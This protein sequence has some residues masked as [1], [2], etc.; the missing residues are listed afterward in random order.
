MRTSPFLRFLFLMIFCAYTISP[1]AQTAVRVHSGITASMPYDG[2][3]S[4]PANCFIAGDNCRYQEALISSAVAGPAG[5]TPPPD[6]QSI[7]SF[8]CDQVGTNIVWIWVQDWLGQWT[9]SPSVVIQTDEE[10]VCPS[11]SFQQTAEFQTILGYSAALGSGGELTMHARDF[12]T[13]FT[14]HEDLS[15]T[16]SFSPDPA[17]SLRTFT[18]EDEEVGV[19]QIYMHASDSFPPPESNSFLILYDNSGVCDNTEEA[20]GFH[21]LHLL[22]LQLPPSGEMTLKA[23]D[24]IPRSAPKSLTYAFSNDPADTLLRLGCVDFQQFDGNAQAIDIFAIAEDGTVS[25]LESNLFLYDDFGHCPTAYQPANDN[26]CNAIPL[27]VTN[28]DCPYRLSNVGAS[29]EAGEVA[30]PAGAC[31][32][33]F[34]WCDGASVDNSLWFTFE[35][36]ASGSVGVEATLL[37]TQIAIWEA[38]DCSSLTNGSAILV[39][40]DDDAGGGSAEARLEAVNFLIPGQ[41]YYLQV[42]G[43]TGDSGSFDLYIW[44]AGLLQELTEGSPACTAAATAPVSEGHNRWLHLLGDDG[45]LIASVADGGNTLGALDGS[46]QVNDG[47]IRR[48][49]QG[50]PYLDRNW[51]ISTAEEAAGPVRLRLYFTLEEFQALQGAGA[52]I[53]TPTQLFL[54]RVPDGA[55][56][57]FSQDGETID[58]L[59]YGLID[60]T[61][62]YIDFEIPG[63]SAF[64]LNGGTGLTDTEGFQHLLP[65]PRLFPNPSQGQAMLSV[66]LGS[67]RELHTELYTLTGQHIYQQSFD[68]PAG[69]QTI[70]VG[71]DGL[72]PGIYLLRVWDAADGERNLRYIVTD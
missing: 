1:C 54:T 39:A 35:A 15:P 62:Y 38:D 49:L 48:D 6:A 66:W 68:L 34:A 14:V 13:G 56:G 67:A 63:F 57:P 60:E 43:H 40:A 46:L 51:Q 8:D 26:A 52:G 9:Y 58:Q 44:D 18:C 69:Q 3:S 65:A 24:F 10:G 4:I 31:D 21:A 20:P 53:E 42:D 25:S 2:S 33:P 28:G 45:G 47:M 50:N 30:P 7:I 70:T 23:S 71:E 19:Y 72:E 41:T 27:E 12:V 22:Q 61:D 32:M 16:F 36:P 37:N 29:A 11:G 55:C 5:N 64:Y 59:E 17:D